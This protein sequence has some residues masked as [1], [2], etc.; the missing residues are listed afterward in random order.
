MNYET[1]TLDDVSE[2]IDYGLT[3]SATSSDTGIKFLRITDIQ[4]NGVDWQSVPFCEC[5]EK[6]LKQY[7]EIAPM[8]GIRVETHEQGEKYAYLDLDGLP[9]ISR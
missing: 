7:Y 4:E 2:K 1:V 8:P 5:S 3:T 9:G 6:D